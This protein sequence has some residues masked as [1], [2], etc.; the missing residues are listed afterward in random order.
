M[1]Q[2][3]GALGKLL[4]VSFPFATA[5]GIFDYKKLYQGF[6]KRCNT[7]YQIFLD[8]KNSLQTHVNSPWY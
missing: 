4:C 1:Q 7:R 5:V 3:R 2:P 8:S 6:V